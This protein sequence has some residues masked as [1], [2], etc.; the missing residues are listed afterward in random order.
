M[1]TAEP[2]RNC[3]FSMS[4]FVPNPDRGNRQMM[5]FGTETDTKDH[6]G[7]IADLWDSFLGF[8]NPG[9]PV[10]SSAGKIEVTRMCWS[11]VSSGLGGFVFSKSLNGKSYNKGMKLTCISNIFT[12]FGFQNPFLLHWRRS[13]HSFVQDVQFQRGLPLLMMCAF[14]WRQHAPRQLGQ[15]RF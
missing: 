13:T 2:D 15:R 7:L 1:I 11:N 14:L 4:F 12:N 8:Q 5:V 10:D 3:R 9:F 6:Q